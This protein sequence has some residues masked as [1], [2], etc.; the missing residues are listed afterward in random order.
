M[1]TITGWL[2]RGGVAVLM[3]LLSACDGRQSEPG[4]GACSSDGACSSGLCTAD[5]EAALDDLEPWPL[6]CQPP[7]GE[8]QAGDACEDGQACAHG[9]CA[10]AGA[11]VAPCEVD[12]DCEGGRCE[13]IFARG[14][15]AMLHPV[16]ACAAWHDLPGD[17]ELEVMRLPDA[18]SGEGRDGADIVELPTTQEPTLFALRHLGEPEWPGSFCRPP[19]CVRA[20]RSMTDGELLFDRDA[21]EPGSTPAPRNPVARLET[22]DP[23]LVYIGNG[24]P[25]AFS[26][27]GYEITLETE[28]AGDLEIIALRRAPSGGRL[29][30]NVFYVG[31]AGWAPEGDRGPPLL[32]EAIERLDEIYAQAGIFVGEVHQTLIDGALVQRG[33]TFERDDDPGVGFA[34]LSI[35]YGTWMELP[36]LMRLSAGAGNPGVNLFLVDSIEAASDTGQVLAITAGTP[37]AMGMQGTAASGIAIATSG[38][39]DGQRLGRTLAHEIGHFLGLFHTTE[40]NGSVWEPLSDTP[41]CRPDRDLDG[42]GTLTV[43]ECE[44]AGADNLMFWARTDATSLTDEQRRILAQAPLLQ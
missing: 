20:L 16:M 21:I 32:A 17:A 11:C 24:S 31:A 1:H 37:G 14:S 9:L 40:S 25:P 22:I 19:V 39:A 13:R 18:L 12:D 35:R 38:V 5:P 23:A 28:A 26:E 2:A 42:D 6:N 36:A 27:L 33:D 10:V 7:Q 30:L 41:E 29:D 43:A 8:L 15:E 44:G 4:G 34:Q 3:T